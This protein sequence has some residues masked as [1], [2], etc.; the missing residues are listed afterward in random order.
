MGRPSGLVCFRCSCWNRWRGSMLPPDPV[1]ILMQTE[2]VPLLLALA[3]SFDDCVCFTALLGT[4]VVNDH[5]LWV[6][7]SYC[8][9]VHCSN[10]QVLVWGFLLCFGFGSLWL[11][12]LFMIFEMGWT[13]GCLWT[14]GVAALAFHLPVTLFPTTFACRVMG[15]AVVSTRRVLIGAVGAQCIGC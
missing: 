9:T 8:S 3:G 7:V 12:P 14:S 11:S 15:R 10:E 5:L 2:V 4:D 1:S 6:H 13:T